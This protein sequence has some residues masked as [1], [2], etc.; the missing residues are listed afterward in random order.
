MASQTL[1]R[2]IA[3]S[4]PSIPVNASNRLPTTSPRPWPHLSAETQRQVAQAMAQLM[5]RMQ[6]SHAKARKESAHAD[7]ITHQ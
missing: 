6:P 5:R 4:P 7:D 1:P 2:R 3:F